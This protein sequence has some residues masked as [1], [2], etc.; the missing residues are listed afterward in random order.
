M[1]SLLRSVSS[2]QHVLDYGGGDGLRYAQVI[3]HVAASYVLA[4]VSPVIV[5]KRQ[6]A[7]DRAIQ[8]DSLPG[9]DFTVDT[10]VMLE[11]LEHVLDPLG[12]FCVAVSK[13]RPGGRIML[14]VPNA[15]NAWNRIRMVGGRLPASGVGGSG[16]RGRTWIAPHIRFFDWSSLVSLAREA[17]VR[18]DIGYADGLNLG[19]LSGCVDDRLRKLR[20]GKHHLPAETLVLVGNRFADL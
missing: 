5:A 13:V 19:K 3:K 9:E 15:F 17:G 12:V 2:G 10:L 8:V 16:V 14:S 11:V 4:D 1:A 18:V 20:S 7:G 6:A